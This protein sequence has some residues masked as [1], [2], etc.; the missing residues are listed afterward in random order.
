MDVHRAQLLGLLVDQVLTTAISD[1]T[2]LLFLLLI[3]ACTVWGPSTLFFLLRCIFL[4]CFV[5]PLNGTG[6]GGNLSV[7][8]LIR[9]RDWPHL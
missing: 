3:F 6:L 1:K 8:R 7:V 4:R 5:D 2:A 9:G